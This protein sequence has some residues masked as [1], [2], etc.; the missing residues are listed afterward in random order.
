VTEGEY[1]ENDQPPLQPEQPTYLLSPE[2]E[3]IN[4]NEALAIVDQVIQSDKRELT[5]DA[6]KQGMPSRFLETILT[7]PVFYN[8]KLIP[9]SKAIYESHF[10]KYQFSDT[11]KM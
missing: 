9:K 10:K 1:D 5:S 4:L 3:I 2:F 6:A 11:E 8:T 7:S